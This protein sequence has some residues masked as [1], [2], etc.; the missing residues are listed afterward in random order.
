MKNLPTRNELMSP[1]IEAI[2]KLGGSANTDEIYEA[3]VEDLQ[4]SDSLLEI[5]DG[6][7]GQ[8]ELQYNL[9]WVRTV[10]KNKGILT[11]G[12]KGIWVLNGD[13]P[14][15][16]A[17]ESKNKIKKVEEQEA[18][19][20]LSE[21]EKWKKDV[22]EIITE[23]LSP[24]SFERLI[25]RILREKGFSQVEVI[26]KTG[27]GGID[28]R[29]IAKI[30]GILSFHIIFQCKRYKGKVSSGEIRD[31]RGAMVGR[32]D[33]GLF[34][35]TGTFTRDAIREANRDGAPA[36]DLMD[37]EKIAEKLKELNLGIDI[38]L[39]EHISIN[40]KWFDDF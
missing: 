35:T 17:I 38:E 34:I 1:T 16:V 40:R 10:L 23:K 29:G 19:E 30:N 14:I 39:R 13:N 6:K 27:D 32:T 15:G 28:G 31:F 21:T 7:T 36:I 37:G 5:I 20:E 3:I 9:A 18:E 33:K 22:I 11:K 4:L 24:S 8:S 26:G 2:K 25:Q 12:G